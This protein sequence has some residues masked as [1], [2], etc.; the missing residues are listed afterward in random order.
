MER[1]DLFAE[2]TKLTSFTQSHIASKGNKGEPLL[3][4]AQAQR[5]PLLLW[6]LQSNYSIALLVMAV[7]ITFLGLF[8]C[9]RPNRTASIALAFATLVP[10]VIA[11]GL[12]L[13]AGSNFSKLASSPTVPEPTEMAAVINMA[14][15]SGFYGLVATLI[16][17]LI[18]IVSLVRST[19][20][21]AD[22]PECD[23]DP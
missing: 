15:S 23:E 17:M 6:F 9:V 13:A 2:E 16:P 4:F 8:L 14:L 21:K 7:S 22:V 19:R 3:L 1:R 20:D 10:G 11:A 12:V 18:A 5:Y